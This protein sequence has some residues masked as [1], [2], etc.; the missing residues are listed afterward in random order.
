MNKTFLIRQ[1]LGHLY[2]GRED[3]DFMVTLL[4]KVYVVKIT[5]RF[6]PNDGIFS[7][8]EKKQSTSKIKKFLTSTI[9]IDRKELLITTHFVEFYKTQYNLQSNLKVL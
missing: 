3:T 4:N 7:R 6:G 9:N 5:T 1:L 2:E 8:I